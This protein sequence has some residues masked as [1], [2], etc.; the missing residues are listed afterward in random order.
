ME[1]SE[2][3]FEGESSLEIAGATL[4]A[5]ACLMALLRSVQFGLMSRQAGP[6]IIRYDSKGYLF[7]LL[8]HI[9]ICHQAT[10]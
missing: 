10:S 7:E 6:V 2:N 8:T 5:L 9:I 1:T 3:I 4:W